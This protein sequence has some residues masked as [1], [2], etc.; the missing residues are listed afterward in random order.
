MFERAS[1]AVEGMLV[2]DDYDKGH[3][4]VKDLLGDSDQE[5][6]WQYIVDS[7]VSVEALDVSST[8]L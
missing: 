7:F 6:R 5:R 8:A 1:L 3:E 2:D 4:R